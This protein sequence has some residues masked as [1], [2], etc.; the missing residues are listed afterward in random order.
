[1]NLEAVQWTLLSLKVTLPV[2]H[3][4]CSWRV[5][6]PAVFPSLPKPEQEISINF[7]TTTVFMGEHR[8]KHTFSQGCQ[9]LLLLPTW[10]S[11]PTSCPACMH[12]IT[13]EWFAPA[14]QPSQVFLCPLCSSPPRCLPTV[15]ISSIPSSSQGRIN[16]TM[17]ELGKEVPY[18]QLS[19]F[20]PLSLKNS[21]VTK[22]WLLLF[23]FPPLLS[24]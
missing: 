4:L 5:C 3:P 14:W 12:Q 18:S 24:L 1:M 8:S 23:S 22:W 20:S 11:L 2:L 21:F 19:S 10:A 7:P 6:W 16:T 17:W 15:S 9:P 13:A